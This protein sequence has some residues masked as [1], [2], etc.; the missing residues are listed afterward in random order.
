SRTNNSVDPTRSVNTIVVVS[1]WIIGRGLCR[2]RYPVLQLSADLVANCKA[3]DVPKCKARSGCNQG[4]L[5]GLRWGGHWQVWSHPSAGKGHGR[6]FVAYG[7]NG[8][9]CVLSKA[10]RSR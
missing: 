6:R 9:P 10:T 2:A 8:D 7:Q 4:E 5:A 3:L 1:V